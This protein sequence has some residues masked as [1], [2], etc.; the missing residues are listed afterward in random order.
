MLTQSELQHMLADIMP[1]LRTSF[2]VTSLAIFGSAARGTATADSDV[3]LL[4]TFD[5]TATVTLLTMARLARRIEDV[6]GHPVDLIEDHAKL[7]PTFRSWIQ[8]D[9]L[10]VA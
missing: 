2:H 7:P 9:L 3:D 6:I 1:E 4:V 5:P 8:Q 10:R